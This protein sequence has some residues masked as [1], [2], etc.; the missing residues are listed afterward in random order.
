MQVFSIGNIDVS[1][2]FSDTA[3][4]RVEEITRNF[5]QQNYSVYGIKTVLENGVWLVEAET[6]G[7]DQSFKKLRI[8]AKTGKI[9]SVE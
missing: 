4:R 8:D 7:H 6:S 9:I 5:L 1:Q 3:R 2:D